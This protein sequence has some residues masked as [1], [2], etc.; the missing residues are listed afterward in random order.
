MGYR[1]RLA[2]RFGV[3]PTPT[4]IPPS[5]TCR[6]SW[7]FS[8]I[9]STRRRNGGE[10]CS[11][12]KLVPGDLRDCDA[13]SGGTSARLSYHRK[14]A[15]SNRSRSASASRRFSGRRLGRPPW[16]Q[17]RCLP[18]RPRIRTLQHRGGSVSSSG[19]RLPV[20]YKLT[21]SSIHI[22]RPIADHESFPSSF[23]ALEAESSTQQ[24][25]PGLQDNRR[26]TP[27]QLPRRVVAR[28]P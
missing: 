19:T 6:S 24:K 14:M 1:R 28:S 25:L 15:V 2:A 9:S 16:P 5:T 18:T 11:T 13:A 7:S 23:A 17:S 12:S 8:M 27:Q 20:Q 3:S 26:R 10:N 22:K 21:S 4:S